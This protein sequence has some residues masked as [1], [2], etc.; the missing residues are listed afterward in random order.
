MRIERDPNKCIDC[1]ACLKNCQGASDPHT[2]LRKSECF[3]CFECIEDCPVDAITFSFMLLSLLGF[4]ATI[5]P[6]QSNNACA[7]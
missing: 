5:E 1:D 2:L 6:N 3:V 4:P 7:E